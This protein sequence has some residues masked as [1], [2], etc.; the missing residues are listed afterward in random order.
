[1]QINHL[2]LSGWTCTLMDHKCPVR[3]K[4]NSSYAVVNKWWCLEMFPH[5]NSGMDS[6]DH[7]FSRLSSSGHLS[8]TLPEIIPFQ[9]KVTGEAVR[10]QRAEQRS[11]WDCCLL[12]PPHHFPDSKHAASLR[13]RLL[14]MFVAS[15][16]V[17]LVW[18]KF[19]I[20]FPL[21]I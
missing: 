10:S 7:V 19:R 20:I 13:H 8:F 21:L 5:H 3:L 14:R 4:C 9:H 16:D 11:E 12:Q 6:Q 15:I 1:M 17:N 18:V 2:S